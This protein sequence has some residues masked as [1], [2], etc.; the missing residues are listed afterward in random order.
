M[1]FTEQTEKAPTSLLPRERHQV[2]F[3]GML[4]GLFL[5]VGQQVVS[6]E[7]PGGSFLRLVLLPQSSR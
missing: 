4:L 3:I 7:R 5:Q 6:L 1:S 2:L